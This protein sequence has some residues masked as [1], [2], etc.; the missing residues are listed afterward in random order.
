MSAGY[1]LVLDLSGGGGRE[2]VREEKSV[3]YF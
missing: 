2:E 1:D 3:K